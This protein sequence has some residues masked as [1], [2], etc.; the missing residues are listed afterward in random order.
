MANDYYNYS[1]DFVPG[2]KVQSLN[3]D[4]EFAA[5]AAAFDKLGDPTTILNGA[6]VG[7]TESGTADNYVVDNGGSSTLVD[8][9]MMTFIPTNTNT[10]A[11]VAALNGGAN[12]A[13]K[14]NDGSALQAGDLIAGIPVLMLWD[15]SGDRW[16]LSGATA[17]QTAASLRPAV[18]TE[19]TTARTL[20]ASD[21]NKLIRCTNASATT[22]TAPSDST[23]D[24]AIGFLCHI[25][26]DGAGQVTIAPDTGVTIVSSVSLATRTTYSSL[27]LIKIASNTY[28]VL[29]DMSLA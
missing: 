23:E 18:V 25:H 3:L 11:A 9:Q 28:K 5:I 1:N 10:G 15:E 16:V 22:I 12:K 2:Q 24:L 21:E 8:L 19:A 7:G 27:S 29:G 14:R 6:G 4:Q 20:T 13:I 17:V 26:S